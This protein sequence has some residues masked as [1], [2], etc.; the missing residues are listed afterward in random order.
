MTNF[1]PPDPIQDTSNKWRNV[2]G[3][4]AIL[5]GIS[6]ILGWQFIRYS[7]ERPELLN[8]FIAETVGEAGE[9]VQAGGDIVVNPPHFPEPSL[10]KLKGEL[11]PETDF[12][13]MAMIVKD[14]KTGAILYNKNEYD[15]RA[16]ASLTKLMSAL[17]LLEKDIDWATTTQVVG[18]DWMGTHMYEGDTYTLQELWDA[19]LIGSSNKAIKSLANALDWPEEAFIERM[20][21]KARELGMSK[22]NFT[23][24]TGLDEGDTSTASDIVILLEEALNH[25]EIL[26][27]LHKPE[28][29]LYSNERGKSHH[30]WNTNWLLLGWI[31]NDL[32]DLK[33]GKT[34]YTPAAGYNFIMQVADEVGHTINVV[35]LGT[36]SHEARFTEARDIA[37]WTFQNY[38]WP[39]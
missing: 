33:G 35:V 4:L 38:E 5:L 7:F 32:V 19:T 23:D 15:D 12:S 20:N 11:I 30:M 39:K 36:E 26:E 10:P 14:K 2:I 37:Y 17:V 28:L 18:G 3:V 29:T 6:T 27:S 24:T 31:D 25:P 34:G 16:I 9:L 8:K 22:T 21:Q 13:A 1:L